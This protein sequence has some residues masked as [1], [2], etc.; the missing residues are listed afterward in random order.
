MDVVIVTGLSGA[1]KTQ[2]VNCMEDMGYYC[3]D[4]MP[5]GLIKN[6]IEL[7]LQDKITIEKAAFVVDIRGG[8]FFDDF[9]SSLVDLKKASV[10]FKVIF[11]EA[12]DEVLIRRF[13]EVR[14]THPLSGTP[15]ISEG[16]TMERQKLAAIRSISDYIIDTSSMKSADLKAE[17][18]NLLTTDK[19]SF[20]V[21]ISVM[22]FGYKNGIPLDADLVFD[23]RFLPNPFYLASMKNLSGNSKKVQDYVMKFE[24]TT[25][26]IEMVYKMVNYLI[27]LYV[28]E[29]KSH[30][31]IAFGC[32][33]GQ[34]RSVV[35]TNMLEEMLKKEDYSIT[36]IHRDL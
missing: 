28:R 17:I 18:S 22:S 31:V 25:V 7:S 30:L 29:G 5:P 8:E 32:T 36:K 3:I 21:T 23:V 11:L 10:S 9:N 12:S 6:F 26:F 2:A 4:N 35:L 15:N 33:G 34:H 27:P 1:G 14:R 20:K 24:E 16:I 19:D 13:K